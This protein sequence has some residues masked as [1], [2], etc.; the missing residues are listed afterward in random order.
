[1]RFGSVPLDQ[2]EGAILAHSVPLAEGRLRKGLVLEPAHLAALAQAGLT[3][4]IVARLGEGDAPEDEAAGA[5]AMAL[6]GPGVRLQPVGTGRVNLLAEGPGIARIGAAQV[7]AVNAADPAITLATV[8]EWARM[9]GGG[10][11]A[12]VKIV[13][14]GVARTRLAAACAA[15]RGA[16]ALAAPVLRQA[17]LIETVI[18]AED[19]GPKGHAVTAERLARLDM[20]LAPP[21]RVPHRTEALARALRQ[22]QGDLVLVLTGSATSDAADVCPAAIRAAGGRVDRF[23]MPVD[24][25]NLLVLGALGPRPV[26]GLPGCARSPALNGADW[27]LERLIC[28]VP[29]TSGDIAGMGVGGLL[30]EIPTRPRPRRREAEPGG[31]G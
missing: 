20:T 24:P 21:I 28:G 17:T 15:G 5:L 2:A 1:M 7:H 3:E 10:M 23:G 8:P 29:V 14:Y 25:G 11:L 6:A 4:V 30:K 31:M 9:D 26:V 12:T 18:G 22:A 16:V 19:P 27:V 13:A